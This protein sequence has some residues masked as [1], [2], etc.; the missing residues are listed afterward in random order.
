[1]D[2]DIAFAPAT[3]LAKLIRTKKLGALEL[4]DFYV[5]RMERLNPKVNAIIGTRLPEARKAARA[6]DNHAR[7]RGAKL[8]PLHGVP[9]TVKESFDLPGLPTTW[10]LPQQANNVPTKPALAVERLERAGA[11]VFG[12]TN[13]PAWL[14]DWQSFNPLYGTTNNPWDLGRTPGGSSGGAAAALAA[15]LT[16]LE[17]GSDIGA[18][19]RDPAH[20]CGVYGH[21]PTFEIAP[22]DGHALPGS[23]AL[24]DISV[25]GPLA[26]SACDLEVA[27][28]IIAGPN[29]CH[30]RGVKLTLPKSEKKSVSEFRVA[31]MPTA[32]CAEVDGAVAGQIEALAKWLRKAGAKVDMTARPVDPAKAHE[33]FIMLLRAATSSRLSEEAHDEMSRER[34][35]LKDRSDYYAWHVRANSMSHHEWLAWDNL[36]HQMVGQWEAF[37]ERFDLLLCPPAATTAFPHNQ[38]GERWERM[39]DVNGKPQPSTTQ[40]FWAGYSG[41]AFLPSTVAPIGRAAD[42]LPVGVQIIAPAYG[43]LTAIKFAQLLERH[44]RAFEAPPGCQ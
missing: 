20:Y 4:L 26:R 16:G 39:I 13:V 43:D 21:K 34:A 32:S 9:M 12:K 38:Q 37:F 1:M 15:G 2:Q 10:G 28:K 22:R 41:M 17:L 42:G 30:A 14:A 29:A 6:R 35:A 33:V 36:R 31:V 3:A 24:G 44:Y 23:Y 5:D 19:I 7:K 18:S 11:V 27:L 25:I 8:G 40:L